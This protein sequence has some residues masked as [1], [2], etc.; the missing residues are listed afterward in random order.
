VARG[1]AGLF[2]QVEDGNDAAH[3]LYQR[4]GFADH[5]GYHYRVAPG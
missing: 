2:L 3:R 1:A 4:T 5:H